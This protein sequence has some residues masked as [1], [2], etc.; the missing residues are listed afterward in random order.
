VAQAF[1][2]VWVFANQEIRDA[3]ENPIQ[4]D[5]WHP[6]FCELPLSLQ[7]TPEPL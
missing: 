6:P 1:L 5:G 4:T 3:E 7:Q 2:I